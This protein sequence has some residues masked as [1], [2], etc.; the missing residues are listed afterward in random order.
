MTRVATSQS[1]RV[2]R[3]ARLTLPAYRFYRSLLLSFLAAGTPPDADS[4][5]ELARGCGIPL[6]ATLALME[7]QDL[8]Q[9]SVDGRIRAAYPFSGVPT[10]HRVALCEPAPTEDRPGTP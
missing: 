10:S 4:L 1:V 6:E 7:R 3:S 9:R 2:C 8:V 5:R